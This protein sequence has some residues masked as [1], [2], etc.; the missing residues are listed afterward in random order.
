MRF[1]EE[2][3]AR[4]IRWIPKISKLDRR[5]KPKNATSAMNS[6][7]KTDYF[8]NFVGTARKDARNPTLSDIR[9]ICKPNSCRMAKANT[10]VPAWARE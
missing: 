8:G 9:Q 6:T 1:L 10:R 5:R 3:G 7:V 4:S 2:L